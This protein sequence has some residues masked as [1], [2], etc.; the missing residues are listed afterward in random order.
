M[1]KAW[2][3]KEVRLAPLTGVEIV[4]ANGNICRRLHHVYQCPYCGAVFV[5]TLGGK[6]KFRKCRQCNHQ[7]S[8]CPDKITDIAYLPEGIDHIPDEK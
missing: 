3:L 4:D 2:I 1:P 7:V 6:Y 5:S 8:P